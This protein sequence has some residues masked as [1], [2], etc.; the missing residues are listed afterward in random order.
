MIIINY[1]YVLW[2]TTAV[3]STDD[4]IN[5]DQISFMLFNM[6][7]FRHGILLSELVQVF[8]IG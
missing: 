5:L 6:P 4:K 8:L 7:N 1:F 3:N 2:K